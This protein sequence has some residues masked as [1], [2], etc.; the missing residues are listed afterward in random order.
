[1]D[2]LP[3]SYISAFR[4]DHGAQIDRALGREF[5]NVT[6]VDVSATVA[7]VQK[8]MNQVIAAI[9]FLFAFALAAG[10]IVLFATL[11]ASRE[12]RAR[13]YAVMRAIGASSALLRSVQRAELLGIGALAGLLAS[14]AAMAAGGVLAKMVFEFA[15]A[16]TFWLP[17]AGML[18][19]ALL[20]LAAGWYGLRE[21]L[22]RPV[23]ETLRRSGEL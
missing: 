10:L 5:P 18:S 3:V 8:V 12:L 9:E 20:A 21:V 14:L 4:A 1:M 17:L 11:A 2:G 13:E 15:W 23:I 6:I 7:Q 16:P 22:R 19:G